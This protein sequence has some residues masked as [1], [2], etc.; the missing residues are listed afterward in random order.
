MKFRTALFATVLA[1]ASTAFA[2]T[3]APAS[4]TG[5]KPH[6]GMKYC[7]EHAQE[8]KDNAAKFDS[9]CSANADKCM[10]LKAWAERRR[11]YCETHGQ[12]C[13]EHMH[14]MHEHMKEWCSKNPDDE[15]CKMMMNPH[16]DEEDMGG[17]MPPPPAM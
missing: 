9:W 11:E 10:D 2:A 5:G 7:S 1:F 8:C 12:E 4:S 16:G 17:D 3:P 6:P 15:H 13:K 14:K